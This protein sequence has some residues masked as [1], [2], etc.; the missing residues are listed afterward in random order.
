[1]TTHRTVI[2][3]SPEL[4]AQLDAIPDSTYRQG[5]IFTPEHDIIIKEYYNRKPKEALCKI[6]GCSENTLRSR[7]RA[8]NS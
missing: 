7:Y 5:F 8:L 2:E 1:M 4:K 3:I 6:I